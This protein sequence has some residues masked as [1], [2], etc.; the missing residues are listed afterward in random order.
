MKRIF[1]LAFF[2]GAG[3]CVFAQSNSVANMQQDL[4]ILSREVGQLRLEIEQLR[5]DNE[6]LVQA[7]KR[8]Q[9]SSGASESIN[10]AAASL[11]TE[12]DSK[13]EALKRDIL[14]QIKKEL[15]AMTAQTNASLKKIVEAM[16]ARNPVATT[17]TFSNNYPQKGISYTIEKGDTLSGIAKKYNSKIK[18][19][20]DANQIVDPSRDLIVGKDIFVPQEQ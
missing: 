15:E 8:V 13:D 18:W 1:T 12:M 20:Q 14:A 17:T 19:I 6:K 2:A 10:A 9:A 11:R 3:L 16:G 7:L 4:A 5:S